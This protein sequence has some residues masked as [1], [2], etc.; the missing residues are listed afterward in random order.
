MVISRNAYG[1]I[2]LGLDVIRKRPDGYHDLRMIMQ[3]VDLYDTLTFE[4]QPQGI[5]LSIDN[6][7]LPVD[8]NNLIYKA[9]KL[10]T[11]TYGIDGGVKITL[12]KRIPIAAGMAGGSTD[13]AATLKGMRDLY[14]LTLPDEE[15]CRIGVRIGADVPYCVMGGTYLAEGIG[16]VLT[17]LP[18]PPKAVLLLAKP[19]I[20]VSTAFVYGNLKLTEKT[21]HPD[22]DTQ[23]DALHKGDLQTLADN[24]GNV[25]ESVTAPAHPVIGKIEQIMRECGAMGAMMSG[26]GPTVF[27]IFT[28]EETAKKAYD[29]LKAQGMTQVYI[30]SFINFESTEV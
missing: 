14:G 16:E 3:T 9:A 21:Y 28:E 18:T 12:N 30:S 11:D 25:L 19:D 15:L 5:S 20:N 24:M 27:G 23:I 6:Q 4:K 22:I 29:V 13:A 8:E 26:S 10:M 17:K 7:E 2:N 1:K